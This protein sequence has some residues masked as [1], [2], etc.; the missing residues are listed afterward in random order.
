MNELTDAV[1]SLGEA[2]KYADDLRR[3]I[4]KT[5]KLA[6][7]LVCLLWAKF[8][9]GGPIRTAHCT[10]TPRIKMIASVPSARR[11][12][13]AYESLMEHLAIP[14][15]VWR[16]DVVRPHWPGLVEHLSQRLE[17]GLPVPPGID[18]DKTY[19][20]YAVTIRSKKGVQE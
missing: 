14:E 7:K 20:D 17:Q 1:Y 18:P 8:T 15:R 12:P 16:N 13:E 10:G 11:D 2:Y 4:D 5:K 9:E 3:E 19:P 6:S